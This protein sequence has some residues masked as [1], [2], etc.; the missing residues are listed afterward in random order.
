MSVGALQEQLGLALL[1]KQRMRFRRKGRRP[2]GNNLTR[3]ICCAG[4]RLLGKIQPVLEV[5]VAR[6]DGQ[7]ALEHSRER[8]G[9]AFLDVAG[10]G[11]GLVV[12]AGGSRVITLAGHVPGEPPEERGGLGLNPRHLGRAQGHQ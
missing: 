9:P 2:T 8:L 5:S 7:E 11:D 3:A 4:R 12:V 6:V 10:G 1:A